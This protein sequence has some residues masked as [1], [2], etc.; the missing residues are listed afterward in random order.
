MFTDES[1]FNLFGCD[2]RGKVW[3]KPNKELEGKNLRKTVKHGGGSVMVWGCMA[4]SGVGNLHFIDGV[5]NKHVYLTI[6]RQNLKDSVRKLGI[7]SNFQFYQDNDPK[8]SAHD[9]KNWLLYNCP[10]V[11]KTPAQSPDLN[12]T[13]HLWD[14]LGRRMQDRQCTSIQNLKIALQEEWSNI[15]PDVCKK[16]VQSMPNRL[17]AVENQKGGATKY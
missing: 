1:K 2:G 12:V 17:Q 10:K 4:A 3:R 14:E 5:M 8:H 16:L 7:E 15:S 11:I 9:V 6:L 13:E